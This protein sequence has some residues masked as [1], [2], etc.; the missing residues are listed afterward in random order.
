MIDQANAVYRR[1]INTANTA[2]QNAENE[3]N[4]RN[5][6]NI[7]QTAQA[8]LLQQHRDELNFVRLNTLNELDYNRTL[9]ISSFAYDRDLELAQDIAV[10]SAGMTV[11]GGLLGALEKPIATALG[12]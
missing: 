12:G 2:I 5:L 7:S 6:F 11:L 9:A 4:T 1:Q 3:F 8:N 10:G